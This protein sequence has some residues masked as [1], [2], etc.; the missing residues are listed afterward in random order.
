MA[1]ILQWNMRGLKANFE[2]LRII[3]KE[4]SP[5]VLCIQ[6][7]KLKKYNNPSL[8]NFI[9]YSAYGPDGPIPY[10]GSSILIKN[11]INH[12][13][14]D[15]NTNFQAIALRVLLH[16]TITICSVYIPPNTNF[17]STDLD[18]LFSQ[19]PMPVLLLGDFN[20]HNPI[21]D[22]NHEA[23]QK[24]RQIE[25][26]LC[27]N[28]LSILNDG[29]NTFLSQAHGTFSAIDLSICSA[30]LL[31]DF[32]WKVMEDSHGSDH[33]PILLNSIT[34]IP[35]NYQP[36]WKLNKANWE[37]FDNLLK[38]SVLNKDIGETP[39]ME[40]ITETIVNIAEKCIP[41]TKGTGQ[42]IHNPW[43]DDKCK[44]AINERKKALRQFRANPIQQN[45][46]LFKI[47]RAKSRQVIKQAKRDS[48]KLFVSKITSQTPLTKVWE[49][50]RCLKGKGPNPTVQHLKVGNTIWTEPKDIAE[51]LSISLKET[52]SSLN[53]KQEFLLH[54]E[55]AE[56][57]SIN[58]LSDNTEGYNQPFT[59]EELKLSLRASRDTAVGSD[60]IHYQ[61]LKHLSEGCLTT[62]LDSFNKIFATGK[63]P[64]CWQEAI[65]IPIPK[66]GKDHSDPKNYRPISLTSCLCKT[67]ERMVNSRLM[68]VLEKEGLLSNFQSGYRKGRSTLDH[69]VSLE[70]YIRNS[71]VEGKHVVSVF[72]DLEKAY[73]L[74]WRFG[75]MK[76][77]HDMGF[78][79]KLPLFIQNFLSDRKF[80]VRVGNNYSSLQDQE[81]GVPQGS[82]LSV[83]LFILKLNNIV[84]Q[85][86]KD[87]KCR[88][89][90]D[91]FLICFSGA[92]MYTI[93]RQLQLCIDNVNQ[94]AIKNGFKFS[95]TK[96]VCM[97]FC[98]K[99]KI[100]PEPRL[101]L[102][103]ELIPV[104]EK[105]RFLGLIFDKKL[106]FKPHIQDLK[107]R[108]GK[109]LDI[110]KCLS[111][112]RWGS[113]RNILLYLYR[114]L[115][116][117]KL[118]YGCIV[119]RSAPKSY[120]NLLNPVHHQGI[121]LAT[122]AFRSSPKE[123]L[124]VEAGEPSL[125]HRQIKLAL[126]FITRIKL[127]PDCPVFKDVFEI[128][129]KI[130]DRLEKYPSR[131]GPLGHRLKPALGEL[132]YCLD[133]IVPPIKN[134]PPPWS[135]RKPNIDLSLTKFKK[136]ETSALTY[137]T[138][139]DNIRS[140]YEN[141]VA[142]Y[143]DGS[144]ENEKVGAA[145]WCR[146]HNFGLRLS[147]YASIF[148]AEAYA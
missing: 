114:T 45:L 16:R 9:S 21:W 64:T 128:P 25:T 117:S 140:T 44:I 52:S 78:R 71:F 125:D 120:L 33:F 66:P 76:D 28:S 104:V 5:S 72:F 12:S 100:H 133:Q 119:Y 59:L 92:R 141:H 36:R 4:L 101:F 55:R 50:I 63:I 74:T 87:L 58:F 37:L 18:N 61:F 103:G 143:T 80:K 42:K 107:I 8:P 121:R 65:I 122:G 102:G 27:N 96:T 90:V 129:I 82:I 31:T 51:R 32:S 1:S 38:E 69:L 137:Q 62:L 15:L 20:G 147:D 138:E 29:S 126:Q 113:D 23:D 46:S 132:E 139:F 7:T 57:H 68:W 124:Y 40:E 94:W 14:V 19:L 83:T 10:G 84:K 127:D 22:T 35:P 131:T 77:L 98:R 48:W 115:V 49:K 142:L 17:N 105:Q 6:E 11:S 73:D 2:E 118:D 146:K 97:H 53:C 30:D 3:A 110:I 130:Q 39:S 111:S 135:L 81:M 91:D 123:S 112:T 41:K 75:V 95:P 109:A 54:K 60:Q 136:A 93:E 43:F 134:Q 34:P 24:G 116:R 108:C 86:P 144:K 89:Y 56:A 106:T 85:V 26:F 67:L 99:R 88:L 148:T 47:Q 70:S 79:G 145:Y 13:F